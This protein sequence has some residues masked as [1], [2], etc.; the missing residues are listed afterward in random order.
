MPTDTRPAALS[1]FGAPLRYIQGPGALSEAGPTAAA[2]GS[3]ALLIA[4]AFVLDL[5]EEAVTASCRQ[6]GTLVT[7]LRFAGE[8]TPAEIE[9]LAM[10]AVSTITACGLQGMCSTLSRRCCSS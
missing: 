1:I 3:R 2:I 10:S 9:R 6:A 7:P 4:D 5:L 8:I